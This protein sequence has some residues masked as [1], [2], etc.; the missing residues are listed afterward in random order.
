MKN[1]EVAISIANLTKY[2]GKLR[3]LDNI[4]FEVKRGDFF[5]FLGPNGAGKTTTI[6]VL[7]GLSNYK[8]GSVQVFGHD[9]TREYRQSRPLIGLCAQEFNFD[10]FLSIHRMLV[11]QAG[12]F[13]I[14]EFEAS[15]RADEL[16]GRFQL[17]DKRNVKHRALSGGMKKRL[18]FCRALIHDP[19]ILI[20][21]EPTAG[22]DLELKFR[23]W[24][25]LAQLNNEG[26]TIFLTTHYMEEAEK[27]CKTIGIINHG[28][29]V[30]IGEKKTVLQDRS[31]ETVF[32]EVTDMLDDKNGFSRNGH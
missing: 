23:I 6:N 8:S 24:D 22:C 2:Y 27:L 3:A 12:Y 18:L 4:S 1:S 31:L 20:L 19:E 10:P 28:Q 15:R 13:G 5:A 29:I 14:P 7:T 25:Y 32:L 17:S 9:V 11:Y 16:L 21:D 30:R 26:K